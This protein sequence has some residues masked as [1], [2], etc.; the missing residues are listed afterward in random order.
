MNLDIAPNLA[1]LSEEQRRLLALLMQEQGIAASKPQPIPRRE[2]DGPAPLSFSQQRLWVIDQLEPGSSAYNIPLGVRIR[3]KLDVDALRRTLDEVVRRH[4][5]LRTVFARVGEEPVQ[6]VSAPAPSDLPVL[7]LGG[8]PEAEREARTRELAREEAVRP[9]DLASGPLLRLRLLRLEAEH[10]VALFTMHHVVSD[11]WSMQVLV[12]EI[13]TLYTAFTRG[14]ASPLEEL[15]VQYPDYAAWQRSPERAEALDRQVDYWRGQLADAPSLL[16][17]PT[18]RPRATARGDAAGSCPLALSPETSAALRALGAREEASLFMTLLAGWQLLLGR[19]ADTDDVSVGMPTAGR[20]RTELEGLIGFFVNTL[21][22]R[23]RL[24]G[25]LGARALLLRVRETVLDAQSNQDVPFD[26]LV[27]VLRIPRDPGHS[28]LFQNVLSLTE[29]RGEGTLRLP[30]VSLEVIPAEQ[31]AAKFDLGLELSDDGRRV[32]GALEFRAALY[33]ESTARRMLDHFER[34]LEWM[35]GQPDRKLAELSLLAG[36]EREQVLSAWNATAVEIPAASI[37][38]LFAARAAAAPDAVALVHGGAM[39]TYGALES[40]ANRLAHHLRARGVG[41]ESRVGV[42]VER[43][44]DTVI[45]ILAILKAGGAYVPLDPAYPAERLAYLLEDSGAAPVLTHS[46]LADRFPA[47]GVELLALDGAAEEIA[48]EPDAAPV[49]DTDP[50]QLAYVVYTSGS[51][52]TP[53][54]V[55]VPHRAVVR[56]VHGAEYVRFGA[57]ETLLQYAPV[58]FDAATFELWGSLLHGARL[59]LAPV[60]ALS[61]EELGGVLAEGGV[62]TLWLTAG[63]FHAVVDE[64]VEVL[65]GVRQLIA[66]GDVV[67]TAHARRFL[68]AHPGSA[69]VNG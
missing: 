43:S 25:D 60:G 22:L 20:N 40:A 23:T 19:Y 39:L 53:K 31:T 1:G 21:V 17:L 26:R 51:T 9:F 33:D 42:C 48:R 62:S 37:H 5:S 30:E 4:E 36:A 11:G 13:S 58:S 66:G 55:A 24:S 27:E 65:R 35:C 44:F 54:G 67:S 47:G 7:D 34:I 32:T 18:D 29:S 50:E 46:A 49:V 6:V 41:P 56:L 28:P 12:R 10:H 16:E 2:G 61:P 8:L 15:T 57:G 3:G 64:R 38:E 63:L 59:V 68:E 14:S 52:G 69:L 45:A